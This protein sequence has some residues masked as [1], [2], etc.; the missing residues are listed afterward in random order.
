MSTELPQ[1]RVKEFVEAHDEYEGPEED[2]IAFTNS[3]SSTSPRTVRLVKSD[4][5]DVVTELE[6]HQ[7]ILI[8]IDEALDD[9]STTADMLYALIRIR[10]IMGNHTNEEV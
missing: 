3:W 7:R 9:T 1:D 8:E 4:V 10:E 6:E 5:R 2:F